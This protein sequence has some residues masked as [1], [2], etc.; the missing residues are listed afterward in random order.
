MQ[1]LELGLRLVGVRDHGAE[2]VEAEGLLADA[3]ALVDE[4]HRP[5]RGQLDEHGDDEEQRAEDDQQERG[6]DA[7]PDLLDQVAAGAGGLRAHHEQRAVQAGDVGDR[8]RVL[9]ADPAR[10]P[11]GRRRASRQASMTLCSWP[12]RLAGSAMITWVAPVA[13]SASVRCS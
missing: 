8:V 9:A 10:R 11:S 4:E 2:L 13:D 7:V 5:A 3:D 6:A 12:L 1:L